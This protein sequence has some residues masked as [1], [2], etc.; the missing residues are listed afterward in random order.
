MAINPFE[1]ALTLLQE[2]GFFSVV[3]PLILIFAVFYGIL[4]KTKVFGESD[5]ANSINA[6]VSFVAAF[7]VVSSTPVVEALHAIIPSAS[8]LL[9]IAMLVLM[10]LAFFGFNTEKQFGEGMTNIGKVGALLLVLIFL[11]MLDL[12]LGIQIPIIH[13]LTMAMVGQGATGGVGTLS[14]ETVNMLISFALLFGV[15]IIVLYLII[16]KGGGSSS[17]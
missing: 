2:F 5:K 1:S 10:L 7:F 6:I 15:P 9:V 13:Q 11:G 12:A 16:K 4:T 14:Q 3:L 17:G 8:L